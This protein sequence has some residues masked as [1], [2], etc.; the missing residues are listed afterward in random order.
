MMQNP[1][2]GTGTSEAPTRRAAGD[3]PLLPGRVPGSPGA[4]PRNPLR[5]VP[6]L[7]FLPSFLPSSV[8]KALASLDTPPMQPVGW[9]LRVGRGARDPSCK[10]KR[11]LGV[12]PSALFN[13]DCFGTIENKPE[14]TCG[15]W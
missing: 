1:N 7:P 12:L 13:L 9:G 10:E 6:S 3:E 2:G 4:T 14:S 11:S 8:T 5:W 15:F